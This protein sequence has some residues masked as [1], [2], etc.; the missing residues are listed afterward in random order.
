MASVKKIGN[1]HRV[2]I[3]RAGHK[4]MTKSFDSA[5]EANDWAIKTEAALIKGENISVTG[6]VGVSVAQAVDRYID[7][8]NDFSPSNNVIAYLKLFKQKCG[9]I[10]LDKLTDQNVFDFI[11]G[12]G[13]SRATGMKVFS[14]IN[15]LFKRASLIWKYKIPDVLKLARAMLKHEKLIGSANKRDRRPE[16]EEI[17]K[18]CAY[19]D[20]KGIRGYD[21]KVSDI[22]RFCISSAMRISEVCSLQW[23][24]LN[25][26]DKTILVRDRKHPTEKIG[27]NQI[28][29]LLDES[30]ENIKRQPRTGKY[31]YPIP[32]KAIT[33]AFH[34]A[35]RALKIKGLHLHDLRH[36]GASRLFEMGY[37]IPEVALFTGHVSWEELKRYT[38]LKAKDIRR[39]EKPKLNQLEEYGMDEETFNQF[40]QF[41]VMMKMMTEQKAA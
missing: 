14:V 35:H 15:A 10:Q 13:K 21:I 8:M 30:L 32:S 36:E 6:T 41:Q 34:M 37:Q 9:N 25:E 17:D 4:P 23:T 40:K 12:H 16:P 5:K 3:R 39:L 11:K 28:V 2:Q 29:P 19:F 24:D 7:E 20:E 1:K 31:I 27:N 38:N 18:I 22:I 33:R 26:K